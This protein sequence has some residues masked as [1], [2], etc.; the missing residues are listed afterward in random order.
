MSSLGQG[1]AGTLAGFDYR[2]DPAPQPGEFGDG[3]TLLLLHGTGGDERQFAPLATQILP[4]AQQLAPRGNVSEGGAPRFFARLAMGRF[5]PAEVARGADALAAFIA[6]AAVEHGIDP[7]RTA[8]LGY[9]N[10]ANV[11]LAAMQR[12][13]GLLGGAAL[14]RPMLVLEPPPAGTPLQSVPVLALGGARD[15]LLPV[16]EFQ[17]LVDVI[18]AEGAELR[19][20]LQDGTGHELT[21]PDLTATQAWLAALTA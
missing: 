13:P 7:A 8:A 10:G 14:L 15:P 5:D 4:G 18:T 19:W 12:H 2:F 3:W 1:H 16:A 9:S 20:A 21:Q 17:R 6:A 11:A